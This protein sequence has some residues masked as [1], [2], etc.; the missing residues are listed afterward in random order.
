[1]KLLAKKG[2]ISAKRLKLLQSLVEMV[3][4][5]GRPF[6][7]I[8]DSGFFSIIQNKL[9]KL[10]AAGCGLNLSNENLPEVKEHLSEMAVRVRPKI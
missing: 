2:D 10:K 8:V 1:M 3:T 7:C 9:D 4:V 5:N 6:K